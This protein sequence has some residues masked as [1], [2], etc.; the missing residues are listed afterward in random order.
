M[1]REA[2]GSNLDCGTIIGLLQPYDEM[3]DRGQGVQDGGHQK[4]GCLLL[5]GAESL[6]PTALHHDMGP[7]NPI[8]G[9]CPPMAGR[10]DFG[11]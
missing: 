4:S 3:E 2:A 10:F 7:T 6:S 5:T 8:E 1:D 9:C 11:Q